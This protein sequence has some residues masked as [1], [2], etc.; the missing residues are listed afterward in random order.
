MIMSY[1]YS[2]TVATSGAGTAYPSGTPNFPLIYGGVRD[3]Q[4]LLF[5]FLLF[6]YHCLSV[7]PFSFGH[8]IV[9]VLQCTASGYIFDIFKRFLKVALITDKQPYQ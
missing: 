8:C 6:L 5:C 9:C 3:A 1:N 4:S 2:T 7:C